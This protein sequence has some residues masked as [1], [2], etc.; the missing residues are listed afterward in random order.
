MHD[1][2]PLSVSDLGSNARENIH[3][4]AT[5]L[6]RSKDRRKV[7]DAIYMGK[8][9]LKRVSDIVKATG[10]PRVRVLQEGKKLSSNRI[11]NQR[12]SSGEVAY[13]KIDFFHHHKRS[14]VA[15]AES[16]K[17]REAYPTKSQPRLTT[18]KIIKLNLS[19]NRGK[20]KEISIDDIDSFKKAWK[21]G[22]T[23]EIP[24]SVSEKRFREGIK[25]ILGEAGKFTDWPGER[26]DLFTGRLLINGK[27][28]AS[29]FIFKGPGT[30]GKLTPGKLGKKGDQVQRL[31]ESPGSVFLVQYHGQIDETVLKLMESLALNKSLMTGRAVIYGLID[32]QD[33]NR[34][35]QAYAH[36]FNRPGRSRRN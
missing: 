16:K 15:L 25:A 14:I 22:S 1:T 3:H 11:V 31:F 13:E 2:A 29:S 27:R 8:R 33:S 35:F 19:T 30:K 9:R 34:I 17:R 12:K 24:K 36:A 4:A 20:A 26:N 23:D 18:P 7:F 28:V 5:I 32:G 6:G 10:L 21:I